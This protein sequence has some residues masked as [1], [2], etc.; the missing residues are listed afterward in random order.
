MLSA[1]QIVFTPM[2]KQSKLTKKLSMKQ[3]LS[4]IYQSFVRKNFQ[5]E[6]YEGFPAILKY[7]YNSKRRLVNYF[8][9]ESN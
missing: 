8:S 4:E 9:L 6:I 5:S 7:N 3:V 1:Q 2:G